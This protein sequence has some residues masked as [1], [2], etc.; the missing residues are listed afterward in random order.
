[1]WKLKYMWTIIKNYME[2]LGKLNKEFFKAVIILL[3][4]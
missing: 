4:L 1:M 3:N 2:T